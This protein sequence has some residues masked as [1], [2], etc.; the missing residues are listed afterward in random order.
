MQTFAELYNSPLQSPLPRS[1]SLKRVNVH[2]DQQLFNCLDYQLQVGYEITWE[3]F[4]QTLHDK[5]PN[6][7]RL[8]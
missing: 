1:I 4:N 6:E 8:P 7:K 2:V 3:Y 5:K